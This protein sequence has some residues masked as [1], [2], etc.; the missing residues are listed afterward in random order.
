MFFE[1]DVLQI[2]ERERER[3]RESNG[4]SRV[5]LLCSDIIIKNI[6]DDVLYNNNNMR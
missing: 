5:L 1:Q 4:V 2:R 6:N 3:E